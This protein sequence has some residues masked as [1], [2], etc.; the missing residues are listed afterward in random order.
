MEID[1]SKKYKNN[2]RWSCQDDRNTKEDP[3]WLLC[4]DQDS[5]GAWI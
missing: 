1:K 4:A 5:L 2:S 3:R